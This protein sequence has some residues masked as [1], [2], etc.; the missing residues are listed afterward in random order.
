MLDDGLPSIAGENGVGQP[1]AGP[2]APRCAKVHMPQ[3][4]VCKNQ[5]G[6]LSASLAAAK[7]AR[8]RLFVEGK[9]MSSTSSSQR[10]LPSHAKSPLQERYGRA[11]AELADRT[12]LRPPAE[13]VESLVAGFTTLRNLFL[14][15]VH[16]DIEEYF[17]ID[18]MLA[19]MTSTEESKE[20]YATKVEIE[21]FNVAIAMEEA[22]RARYIVAEPAWL[23]HWFLQLR[24][25]DEVPPDVHHRLDGYLK[26][27]PDE[28]RL[29]FEAIVEHKLP[30]A[31]R[32]PLIVYRL[33]PPA[34]RSAMAVAFGDPLRAAEHRNEQ[35]GLLPAINDCNSCHGKPL[36]NGEVCGTCG[37]PL[38]KIGWLCAAD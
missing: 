32:V 36:D 15:R 24:L 14:R 38:W 9:V 3:R 34:V 10:D 19:P 18:S 13:V 30:E 23:R 27:T 2:R 6:C 33:Y 17:G 4:S 37:N 25:G 5:N 8:Q 26:R 31:I 11:I 20:L 28:Q 21:V 22:Q 16:Q 7:E 29:M 35:L 1:K 12:S